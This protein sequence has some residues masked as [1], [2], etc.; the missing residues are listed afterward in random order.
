[1]TAA[2]EGLPPGD[3]VVRNIGQLVTNDPAHGGRLGIIW[4]AA[5]VIIGGIVDWVGLDR[6][7]PADVGEL[8]E[9][10][11]D[12]ACVIPGFVDAHTHVV[13]AGDRVD[14][15]A[16]RLR[17]AT[18][19][20]I[21]AR[22]GGILS[23]VGPTRRA[24]LDGLVAATRERLRVMLNHG[25]TTVEVK[26]G[27]ALDVAGE[28]KM[29]EAVAALDAELA[30]DLIPTFLGAHAVPEE[31]AGDRAAYVRL[32]IDEMLPACAPLARFC[33]VFCDEGAF[34]VAEARAVLVA[35][36]SHGLDV[37][38]HADQLSATGAGGLAAELGATA[39]DHLDHTSDEDV[40]ALAR[41]G[42]I[43][44]L[45][46]GVS[47]SLRSAFP[48]PARFRNAGMTLAIATDANPGSSYVLSMPFIVALAV[49]EMGMAP[50]DALWAA[51]LGGAKALGL[52]DR[53]YLAPGAAGDLVALDAH[54]H[55]VLSYRPDLSH[56]THV[57]KSGRPQVG[58]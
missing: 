9:M 4:D 58:I 2:V 30:L 5:V 27:Y 22:G 56:V 34:D 55:V 49:L 8:P 12:G 13:F 41:A 57:V 28:R 7:L 32:V 33:D 36:R 46:P 1:M 44:V 43:G 37:R 29:L 35:G 31:Y 39:A 52:G 40:N 20:E 15:F 10:D 18:Y 38:V 47:L 23:T 21:Q 19:E 25:T 54:S 51:T 11:A 50:E 16:Q 24:S 6:E 53:G 26:S 17:G 14:E 45:L 3:L 48:D 42:T